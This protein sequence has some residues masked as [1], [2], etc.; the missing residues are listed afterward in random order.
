MIV[1]EDV[2]ARS[3]H[4]GEIL[5]GSRMRLMQERSLLLPWILPVAHKLDRA[6][7]GQRETRDVDGI[8]EGVLGEPFARHVVDRAAAVGSEHVERRDLLAE[9]GLERRAGRCR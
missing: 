3:E 7:V 9:A 8:A 4:R 1:M 5:A 2:R 6:P